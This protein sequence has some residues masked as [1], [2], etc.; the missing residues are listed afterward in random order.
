MKEVNLLA[1]FLK[2][3]S[4]GNKHFS[5]EQ[6]R[7]AWKLPTRK[8]SLLS[9]HDTHLLFRYIWSY[10]SYKG[11]KFLFLLL[12]TWTVHFIE[13]KND[14]KICS[15]VTGIWQRQC[16]VLGSTVDRSATREIYP[17]MNQF[18]L[19]IWSWNSDMF[20]VRKDYLEVVDFSRW[21]GWVER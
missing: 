5:Q 9:V 21:V 4:L 6:H 10:D 1:I 14:Q 12:D 15:D 2:T 20:E 13:G 11:T 18:R 19:E 7:I 3:G 8:P 17:A 16:E